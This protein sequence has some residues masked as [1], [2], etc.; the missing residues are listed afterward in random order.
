MDFSINSE[1]PP[2]HTTIR[3]ENLE[4]ELSVSYVPCQV[5]SGGAFS[6][7]VLEF[8]TC[9]L[10]AVEELQIRRDAEIRFGQ[11]ISKL[12]LEKQEL[13]WQKE[14]LQH[15]LETMMQQ[16]TEALVSV[17]KQFQGKMK[18]IEE[19]KGIHQLNAQ[20]KD[21]VIN[22]LKE[23]LKVLQLSSYSFEKK[24]SELEQKLALQSRSKDS[25]LSQLREVE[26]RFGVLSRLCATIKQAHGK[27]ESNVDEAM[28]MNKKLASI[29]EKQES[30]INSLM[31]DLEEMNSKLI[32][33]QVSSMVDPESSSV[34]AREQRADQLQ[35]CL[36][37]ETEMNKKLMEENATER[38]DK[39]EL[40]RSLQVAQQLLLC[41]TSALPRLEMELH[42]HTEE[43][44]TLKRD[45]EAMQTLC[46]AAEHRVASLTEEHATIK[47]IWEK[48]R[49][50]LVESIEKEQRDHQST[51]DVYDRLYQK[52]S[53][54]SPQTSL[55]AQHTP[56]LEIAEDG[57]AHNITTPLFCVVD[58]CTGDGSLH[59]SSP[60]SELPC[61]GSERGCVPSQTGDPDSVVVTDELAATRAMRGQE[62]SSYHPSLQHFESRIPYCLVATPV[63]TRNLVGQR[64]LH[65]PADSQTDSLSTEAP[66]PIT[67]EC[68]PALL[69]DVIDNNVCLSDVGL[70]KNHKSSISGPE[71]RSVYDD[72]DLVTDLPTAPGRDGAKR[73]PSEQEPSALKAEGTREHGEGLSGNKEDGCSRPSIYSSGP[74]D[75]GER[76]TEDAVETRQGDAVLEEREET[77]KAK[78]GQEEE[79][80]D[81]E[82]KGLGSLARSPETEIG[83]MTS[84]DN[85]QRDGERSD[86]LQGIDPLES[87]EPPLSASQPSTSPL[88]LEV[89]GIYAYTSNLTTDSDAAVPMASNAVQ[90]HSCDVES[91]S[92]CTASD[93]EISLKERAYP[94]NVPL[95]HGNQSLMCC[96]P[97]SS[98][99]PV[100]PLSDSTMYQAYSETQD[101]VKYNESNVVDHSKT[102]KEIAGRCDEPE[103]KESLIVTRVVET[104]P[105]NKDHSYMESTSKELSSSERRGSQIL[106]QSTVKADV[107]DKT[108]RDA[109]PDDLSRVIIVDP[110]QALPAL[111]C[112][113]LLDED[114]EDANINVNTTAGELEPQQQV[115]EAEAAPTKE[116]D[117]PPTEQNL[118]PPDPPCHE[119]LSKTHSS[120]NCSVDAD[121]LDHSV[122]CNKKK[123]HS[124]F[125]WTS[126]QTKKGSARLPQCLSST[127]INVNQNRVPVA[128]VTASSLP[129][130]SGASLPLLSQKRDQHGEWK[131][132]RQA[133]RDTAAEDAEDRGSPSLSFQ[134][135]T[136][137]AEMGSGYGSTTSP[138]PGP[139]TGSSSGSDLF[140]PSSQ[141]NQQ[142]S[143]RAQISRIEQFL[144]TDRLRRPKRRQ[145]EN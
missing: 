100:Y 132:I 87:T 135:L 64:T 9:L 119:S 34:S 120:G 138:T 4:Q 11:Q 2:P 24:S 59:E 117:I 13:E 38:A 76:L 12:V 39:Q 23:E 25:H 131:A 41:Q 95:E 84:G 51:R 80:M 121:I 50:K 96:F 123:F 58:E 125:E 37:M 72:A 68:D 67:H 5:E 26:K 129:G 73:K 22:V 7:Q 92:L 134:L 94:F 32:K 101:T 60:D 49:A 133:F 65:G 36:L 88:P 45:H 52:Q 33:V 136:T 16:N 46:A 27:L 110:L 1:E 111:L 112:S 106:V 116:V 104:H 15:Q 142:S 42:Q 20:S 3:Q 90:H 56:G 77:D 109:S 55:Q 97:F 141:E 98:T 145:T 118:K 143:L 107:K 69:A 79:R 115:R 89:T 31:Q 47:T 8:K 83:C 82:A 14:S 62:G 81:V 126:F 17:K 40:M 18:V 102:S 105:P 130:A 66:Y 144:S 57:K 122:I 113:A 93:W 21:N 127:T 54:L 48:E 86:A 140:P 10:D 71:N 103:N 114:T 124:S 99:L 85:T 74:E 108:K 91:G 70:L 139:C 137:S 128:A 53:V 29:N 19:E 30:T 78:A 75:V 44:Q 43:Y 63:A 6:L 28:R 61:L 35:Q